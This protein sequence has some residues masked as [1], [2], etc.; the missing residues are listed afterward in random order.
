LQKFILL[1]EYI[2]LL[3]KLVV[4]SQQEQQLKSTRKKIHN[5]YKNVTVFCLMH[6][7]AFFS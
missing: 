4:L 3:T 1:L 7:S 2:I 5:A 6:H